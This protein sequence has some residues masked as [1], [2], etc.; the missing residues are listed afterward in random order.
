MIVDPMAK[1][2]AN[3]MTTAVDLLLDNLSPVANELEASALAAIEAIIPSL[4]V[5]RAGGAPVF[6]AEGVLHGLPFFLKSRKSKASLDLGWEPTEAPLYTSSADFTPNGR[7]VTVEEFIRLLQQLIGDLT[8]APFPY[9]FRGR[10]VNIALKG[11]GLE[12]L[13]QDAEEVFVSKGCTAEEAFESIAAPDPNLHQL[14]LTDE[15]QEELFRLQTID[16]K[17]LRP[18]DRIFPAPEPVFSVND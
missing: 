13:A 18:D 4:R 12:L 1:D 7:E 2:N 11:E 8:R 16:P 3:R 14:G 15:L 6:T 9:S 17:P 5:V 10:R